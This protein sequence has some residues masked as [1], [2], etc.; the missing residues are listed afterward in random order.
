MQP[1]TQFLFKTF[2]LEIA[3]YSIKPEYWHAGV[4]LFLV[5]SIL[6]T[7]ARYRQLK[8]KWNLSSFIPTLILGFSLAIILETALILNGKTLMT[9]ILGWENA[10]KPIS[11]IINTGRSRMAHVL[12][13][14]HEVSASSNDEGTITEEMLL[15]Y[16]SMN[17]NEAEKVKQIICQ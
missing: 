7:L 1:P 4:I 5:F 8:I 14:T 9:E 3:G 11:T 15:L 2:D 10:P 12:G 6:L 16:T 13:E 17:Q